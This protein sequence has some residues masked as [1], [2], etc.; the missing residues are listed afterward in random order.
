MTYYIAES[1][2][3][4]TNCIIISTEPDGNHEMQDDQHLVVIPILANQEPHN[5]VYWELVD[6]INEE[7]WFY[8]R[9]WSWIPFK[10]QHMIW[11]LLRSP[12]MEVIEDQLFLPGG[13]LFGLPWETAEEAPLYST[14]ERS[15][16]EM[17]DWDWE[18]IEEVTRD[19]FKFLP[20]F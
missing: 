9:T 14:P 12:Y 18:M 11:Y 1:P 16:E 6:C 3:S 4:D 17:E 20:Y 15:D 10:C 13:L 19:N 8:S 7:I 2:E 5:A